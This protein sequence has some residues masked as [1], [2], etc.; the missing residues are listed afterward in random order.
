MT[1]AQE[2]AARIEADRRTAYA[3]KVGRLTGQLVYNRLPGAEVMAA[4]DAGKTAE[5]FAAEVASREPVG[6]AVHALKA[7]AVQRA[8]VE[9]AAQ[10][11]RMYQMLEA[12]GWNLDVVAPRPTSGMGRER[13]RAA[14]ARNQVFSSVTR[15]AA[16][17]R[18]WGEPDIRVAS[19][20]DVARFI[21]RAERDAATEYDA[22]ICKLVA[23]VGDV[24]DASLEGDHVWSRSTLTVTLPSGAVQRWMTQQIVN[25]SVLGLLFNQWPT[26]LMK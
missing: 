17:S 4:H 24:V 2:K 7:A 26:R 21:A 6:R 22:F 23:K 16:T 15:P 19:P 1:K 14:S 3:A 13:Y 5:D 25:V 18:R 9:A 12:A 8:G 10:A 11:E 20:E